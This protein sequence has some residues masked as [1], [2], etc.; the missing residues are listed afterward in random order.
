MQ[1]AQTCLLIEPTLVTQTSAS[2]QSASPRRPFAVNVQEQKGGS[3]SSPVTGDL[4]HE[5]APIRSRGRSR[6][7]SWV[8]LIAAASFFRTR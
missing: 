5:R 7:Q 3:A 1:K 4:E 2:A 6:E 8:R